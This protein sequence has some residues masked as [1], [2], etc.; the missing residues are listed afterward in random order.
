MQR[1]RHLSQLTGY[2]NNSELKTKWTT[3][4]RIHRGKHQSPDKNTKPVG[5]SL[6][7]KAQY[8]STTMSTVKKPSRASSLPQDPGD[9]FFIHHAEINLNTA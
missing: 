2:E 5:A 6:L 1:S 8:Q 9:F 7:A 3:D 4:T